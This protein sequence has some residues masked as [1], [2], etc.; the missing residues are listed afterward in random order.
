MTATRAEATYLM[1]LES[2]REHGMT[3][4]GDGRVSEPNAAALL[5]WNP[6]SLKNAR[7]EGRGPPWYPIGVEGGRVSYRLEHL[8][9]WIEAQRE[10]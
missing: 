3:V 5:G 6:G 2:A 9:Q 1:L 10:G 8:A 4:T 7:T